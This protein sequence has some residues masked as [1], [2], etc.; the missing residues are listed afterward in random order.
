MRIQSGRQLRLL[1]YGPW[2]TLRLHVWG[3]LLGDC[4]ALSSGGADIICIRIGGVVE[5][6]VSWDIYPG[7]RI[8]K[9]VFVGI[10]AIEGRGAIAR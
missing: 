2:L 9:G 1:V 3:M 8:V 10:E 6:E 7:S 4:P 5:G